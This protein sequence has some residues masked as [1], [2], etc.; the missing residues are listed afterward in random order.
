M[1]GT[2]E[3]PF[4]ADFNDDESKIIVRDTRADTKGAETELDVI[5]MNCG[6]KIE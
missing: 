4:T 5:C 2:D 1:V 6:K 3:A